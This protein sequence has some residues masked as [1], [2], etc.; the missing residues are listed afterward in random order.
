LQRLNDIE[1][2]AMVG[3]KAW[4]KGMSYFCLPFTTAKVRYFEH[5]DSEQ[6]REWVSRGLSGLPP[7]N[8][9]HLPGALYVT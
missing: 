7:G 5:Q 3:D 2:L 8:S 4:E 6:A 1:R 9:R